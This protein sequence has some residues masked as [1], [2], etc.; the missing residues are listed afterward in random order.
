MSDSY[1]IKSAANLEVGQAFTTTFGPEK[2]GLVKVILIAGWTPPATGSSG[3]NPGPGDPPQTDFRLA[4]QLDIYKPGGTVP[5]ASNSALKTVGTDPKKDYGKPQV[6]LW[7]DTP[8]VTADLGG[9][10]TAKVTNAGE[11]PVS[12]NV[13]VRYQRVEGNLGKVDHI[14]VLMMENRS[15]DHMLGYLSLENGRTDVDG[16]TKDHVNSDDANNLHSPTHRTDT[17]FRNDPGHGWCDVKEQLSFSPV[18]SGGSNAGF[19]RNFAKVLARDAAGLPPKRTTL[20]DQAQID[21]GNSHDISFHPGEAGLVTITTLATPAIT[22]SETGKLGTL[23]LRGPAKSPITQTFPIQS[24]PMGLQY[25]ATA[26]ELASGGPWTCT[27]TNGTETSANFQT[28]ISYTVAPHDVSQQEPPEAVMSYYNG[29]ELPAYDLLA[30]EYAICDRWFASL[31]TDTWPNR[32]YGLA[33]GTGDAKTLSTS[34]VAS[35]PPAYTFKNIF[36]VLQD[37]G[38]EWKIFFSDLPFALVFKNFAQNA[39]YTQR[40]RGFANGDGGDLQHAVESGDL[41]SFTWIDPNFSDFRE[42]VAAASDDHPPGDVTNGQKLVSQIYAYLSSSPAWTKTL[43]IITYDEHGGFFDHVLPPGTSVDDC[44]PS[45]GGP[46][47]CKAEFE[48]YGLRVPAFVISPWV[49]PG[50]VSHDTFDH[51][52]V[53]STVLHRFCPDASDSLGIRAANALDLSGILSLETPRADIPKIG[54]IPAPVCA[55][56]PSRDPHSFGQVLRSA[57]F[58]L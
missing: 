19:V 8:A 26:D 20:D 4:V 25:T 1:P 57:I 22:H 50:S 29:T 13:T 33:G 10:W 14:V 49:Q 42:S 40:L 18:T 28:T 35:H 11:V 23:T 43:F 46:K 56:F 30:R 54:P 32:L 51:T 6:V 17:C 15:F 55:Q 36:D 44:V 48:R 58:G 7:V 41:P 21:G 47:D 31:P 34:D 52:S 5:A 39:C 24:N 45:P 38:V 16:L 9:D 3:R 53:L 2:A 37:K 27:V 12:C